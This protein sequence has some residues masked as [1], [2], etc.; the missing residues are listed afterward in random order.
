M[1][2]STIERVKVSFRFL[3]KEGGKLRYNGRVGGGRSDI[4]MLCMWQSRGFLGHAP[5]EKFD[6][7]HWI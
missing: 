6:F 5:P 4:C 7:L 1:T 3:A 2:M